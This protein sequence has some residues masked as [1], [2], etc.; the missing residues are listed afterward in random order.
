MAKYCE[1]CG[2][3]LAHDEEDENICNNCKKVK[4][5]E[6]YESDEDFIDPGVT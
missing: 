6:E 2:E 1:I 4:S 3:E 5:E